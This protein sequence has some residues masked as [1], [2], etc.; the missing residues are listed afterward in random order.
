MHIAQQVNVIVILEIDIVVVV[1]TSIVCWTIII[2][3]CN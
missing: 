2:S 3:L 1:W